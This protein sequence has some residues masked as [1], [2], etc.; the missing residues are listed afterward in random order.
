VNIKVLFISIG[1]LSIEEGANR[2]SNKKFLFLSLVAGAVLAVIRMLFAKTAPE[3]PTSK[4]ASYEVIDDYIQGQMRRLNIPGVSLAIVEGD[5]IVHYRGFGRARPGGEAP[6]PQTPFFIGSLTKSF[7]AL[8]IMQL[9]EAGKVELDAPVQRYL[10]WFR[11]ADPQAS[12]Q[13]TVR[14]LLNQTSGLPVLPGELA[15]TDFDDCPNA[16]ERQARALSGL[17]LTRPVGSKFEYS[18]LNYNL[19]GL[20]L[21]ATSGES[22]TD[23]IQNHIF[24]PLEMRHSYTSKAAAQHDSLA[25]GH[26]HWFSLPFPAPN[27]P[28]PRGSL[29]SGWLISCAEDMAHYLIAHL[30]GGRYGGLQ[31][32]S[33]AGIDE[34][35]RG[36]REY[37]VGSIFSG[38]Y[39]M[40][41]FDVDLGQTKTYSHAGNVPN[42]SAFMALIPKHKKG[43]VMLLNADPYGLPPITEEFGL[44]VTA[45]LAGQQPAPIR[46]DFVQ[47]IMRSL[48]LIPL[49]HV[50]GI[51]ATLRSLRRWRA[52]PALRPTSGRLWGQHILL[53][54]LPNL[55]FAAITVYLRSSGLL[56]FM[57]FFMPD[58][59]WIAR[60]CG[61]IAGVW[62]FLRTG[63]ILQTLRKSLAPNTLRG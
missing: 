32:L 9:V 16:T 49:L 19:L 31:I 43:V 42:F 55:S 44:G 20:I 12:A 6:T 33:E 38:K 7:T 15:L 63:L 56:R 27:L 24:D 23:T 1:Y 35:H 57:H 17:E 26:R 52:D 51:L 58:L 21:E 5:R 29:P 2:M 62:A 11:V 40:G 37:I 54:L 14:H 8:A 13:M 59:A 3:K 28:V 53:P 4:G 61:G 34:L 30:N 10:P 60:I 48:P 25:M 41:W 36:V 18:N 46:L 50:L 39:G 22:Y 47:W 45:I